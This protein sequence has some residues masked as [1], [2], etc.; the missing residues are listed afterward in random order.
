MGKTCNSFN[1]NKI[2]SF[3]N[4]YIWLMKNKDNYDYIIIRGV[5][6]T[7]NLLNKLSK[8]YSYHSSLFSKVIYIEQNKDKEKRQIIKYFPNIINM[9]LLEFKYS[10]RK[11]RFCIPPIIY[12]ESQINHLD[13]KAFKYDFCFTGSHHMGSQ[14][15]V[16][17]SVF[18]QYK[19]IKIIVA[20]SCTR[21]DYEKIIEK[22]KNTYKNNNN[23]IINISKNG[24]SSTELDNIILDSRIGIRLDNELSECV[25]SKLLNYIDLE[26]PPLIQRSETHEIIFGKDYELFIDNV[27]ITKNDII[28]ILEK[29]ENKLIYKNLLSDVKKAKE[30]LNAKNIINNNYKI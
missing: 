2:I 3:D 21:I 24:F 17:L 16:L 11:D 7:L 6:F 27:I 1:N 23:I 18:S 19:N 30:I 15:E 13:S 8:K 14:L 12:E 9:C 10:T 22:L 20:G 28:D 25:S 5:H 26:K 29:Y 4:M